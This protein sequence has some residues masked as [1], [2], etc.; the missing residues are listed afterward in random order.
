M[1]CAI[2][3]GQASQSQ[4]Q[5][6]WICRAAVPT[7]STWEA[8]DQPWF[9]CAA[10]TIDTFTHIHTHCQQHGVPV[11]Q[12]HGRGIS[13]LPRVLPLNCWSLQQED[14]RWAQQHRPLLATM[15]AFHGFFPPVLPQQ[16][17]QSIKQL[18]LLLYSGRFGQHLTMFLSRCNFGYYCENFSLASNYLSS[19][20]VSLLW[21]VKALIS[22][23]SALQK[24]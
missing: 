10:S 23:A 4:E 17:D 8:G 13:S 14:L 19:I 24:R 15:D 12:G 22:W 5:T 16:W 20:T 6:I 7:L 1:R 18:S 3:L 21:H 11:T 2:L 9:H